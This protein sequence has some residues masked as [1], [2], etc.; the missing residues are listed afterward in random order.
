VSGVITSYQMKLPSDMGVS[1]IPDCVD[2]NL[3]QSASKDD[4]VSAA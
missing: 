1:L 3:T 4:S 2:I